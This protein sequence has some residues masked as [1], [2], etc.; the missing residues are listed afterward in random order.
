MARGRVPWRTWRYTRGIGHQK[1]PD[2]CGGSAGQHR[3]PENA[4]WQLLPLHLENA[5]L[6]VVPKSWFP[7]TH[8]TEPVRGRNRFSTPWFCPPWRSA[9]RTTGGSLPLPLPNQNKTFKFQIAPPKTHVHPPLSNHTQHHPSRPSS[10]VAVLL[11]VKNEMLV[12]LRMKRNQKEGN[13]ISSRPGNLETPKSMRMGKS[14][15]NPSKQGVN[16]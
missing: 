4:E 7:S 13:K 5:A 15:R 6:I 1:L 8:L 11:A 14:Q 9:G 2:R 16:R 10:L 12:L 3:R